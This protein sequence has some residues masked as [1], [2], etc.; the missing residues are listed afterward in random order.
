MKEIKNRNTEHNTEIGRMYLGMLYISMKQRKQICV[1][2]LKI[3]KRFQKHYTM[4]NHHYK[5]FSTFMN[6]TTTGWGITD[7]NFPR[8]PLSRVE[9]LVYNLLICLAETVRNFTVLLY[10]SKKR[11]LK[12]IRKSEKGKER[13][14]KKKDERR[15]L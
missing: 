4:C 15:K 8:L 9:N 11:N 7:L 12:D 3:I 2:S 14:R 13:G 1:N 6:N 10:A 5:L